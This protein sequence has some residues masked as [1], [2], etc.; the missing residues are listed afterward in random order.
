MDVLLRERRTR[1]DGFVEFSD[2]EISAPAV[3]IG[4]GPDQTLQLI[5]R[6][7]APRH[8]QLKGGG[9]RIDI[10]C[11]RGLRV[12]VNGK[13]VRS[14]A[15]TEGD[16][17]ELDGHRLQI[18]AAPA[19]FDFALELTPNVAVKSRDFASAF[20]NDLELTWLS[21]RRPAWLLFVVILASTLL[22]PLSK[23]VDNAGKDRPWAQWDR[24]WNTGPL[25]P[26]HALAVADDCNACHAVPFHRARDVECKKC[27]ERTPDHIEKALAARADLEPIRCASCHKEH[28]E[29]AHMIVTADKLCTDCHASP[30]R[31]A[32]IKTLQTATGFSTATHPKFDAYLLRSARSPSAAGLVLDWRFE[33]TS[34]SDARESSNL[35]FPHD[36]HLD[37]SKVRSTTDGNALGCVDCHRLLPDNEHFAPITMEMHCR[38]CHDLK[39]DPTDPAR[40]LPHGQPTEAILTIEGHYLRKF[41]D[42]NLAA[43]KLDRR[44][45]PD[46]TNN[47]ERCTDSAF[48]CASRKTR[49]EAINQFTLRGCVTCHVVEDSKGSDIYG[50]FQVYPIRLV[51]D[52]LPKAR[53][54]HA[55]H[56][57]QRDKTGDDACVTCHDASK[58]KDSADLHI[59]D[60]D[61]CVGCHSDNVVERVDRPG[62]VLPCIGCHAYHPGESMPHLVPGLSADANSVMPPRADRGIRTA[63]DET[64]VLD[65]AEDRRRD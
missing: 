15:L 12:V 16:V 19:G 59:P 34:I 48:V 11:R 63:S 55:R 46:R 54:D 38:G 4:S 60:I 25:L 47:E 1:A 32:A 29:P 45:L 3:N 42:P 37:R 62:V 20:V 28:N 65:G 33:P 41:S 50:R 53:F 30:E 56:L 58:S 24:Q 2:T 36:V 7:V 27:H 9:D 35:K 31:F 49:D 44:R 64:A 23:F 13:S 22:L 14:A 6:N 52:Y 26:A 8:A 61:T 43:A 57:T 18:V 5:G 10:A 21:K 51:S 39:F 17:V 40:E